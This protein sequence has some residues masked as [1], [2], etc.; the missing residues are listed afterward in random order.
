MS[1]QS[2]QPISSAEPVEA[3]GSIRLV[4]ENC[5][6]CMICARECPAWCIQIDS[7]T[8]QV[9]GEGGAPIGGAAASSTSGYARARQRSVNVLDRFEIDWSLCMYCGICV[10]QCPFDAL[11]WA[12]PHVSS[13]PSLDGLVQGREQL[14]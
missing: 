14:R 8:E 4:E 13:A 9:T 11:E 12:G 1:D 10:E 6:S 5:T 3:H 2:Q 7:H